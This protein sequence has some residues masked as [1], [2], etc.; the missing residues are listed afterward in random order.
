MI[1]DFY[2]FFSRS[3]AFKI[4]NPL[5]LKNRRLLSTTFFLFLEI[6]YLETLESDNPKEEKNGEDQIELEAA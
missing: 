6:A 2:F 5:T 4:I 3:Y 1:L